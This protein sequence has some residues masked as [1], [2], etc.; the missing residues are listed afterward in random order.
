MPKL[1]FELGISH[2]DDPPPDRIEDLDKLHE[3]DAFRE[4][5]ELRGM[6]RGRGREKIHRM[7]ATR[8]A[9][10]IGV[11]RLK[12]RARSRWRFRQ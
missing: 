7:R 6:D 2:Y 12:S 10:V 4:A 11:T 9:G 8:V 5:N 3:A 1:P